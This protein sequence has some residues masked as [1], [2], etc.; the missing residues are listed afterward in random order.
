M[1]DETTSTNDFVFGI[2]KPDTAEGIVVFAESQI[3]GRGQHG[4]RWDSATGKG[5]WLSILLRPKTLPDEAPRLTSWAATTIA[6]TINLQLSLGASVKP[7]NDVYIADRKVAGVLLELRAVPDQPHVAILGIGINVNHRTEDF[8]EELRARA[9][10]LAMLLGHA[11]DRQELAVALLCN[12]D[13]SYA[14]NF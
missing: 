1:L 3:A 2:A 7:P 4:N 10:S 14:A 13:R 11:V 9:A 8:P 6:E 5:L 12:L